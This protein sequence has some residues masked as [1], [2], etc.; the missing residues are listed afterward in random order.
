MYS[1]LKTTILSLLVIAFNNFKSS[2]Q[3][4]P[5]KYE[6]GLNVGSLIYQGDLSAGMAGYTG[7]IR[8]AIGLYLTKSLDDYFSIRIN[9][10]RG[11]IG[12]DESTYASPAWRRFRNL[13]FS[14]SVTEFSAALN[15][16]LLGKTYREGFRRFSPYF[17]AGA[18]VTILNVHRNWS[19]FNRVFFG[20]K[21]AA[22]IGLGIDTLRQT[23]GIIAVIPLGAGL[24]YRLTDQFFLN[25]EMVYRLT[26]SD[27]VDGFKYAGNPARDDHYYGFSV[28][29]SYRFGHYETSCPKGPF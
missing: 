6:V 18:G 23:P 12:A 3:F 19:G 4:I 13:S 20:P 16:D 1:I 25:V 24:R 27:Y 2:G 17:F 8:P 26:A 21:S 7:Y 29:V 10:V 14:S 11:R 9:G 22:A 28:G 5:S 15:W